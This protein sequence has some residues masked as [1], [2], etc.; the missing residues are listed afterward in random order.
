VWGPCPPIVVTK[1]KK[2]NDFANLIR[3]SKVF[4]TKCFKDVWDIQKLDENFK[5]KGM[6]K[7]NHSSCSLS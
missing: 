3:I 2:D 4:H 5:Q 1:F 7:G 6:R